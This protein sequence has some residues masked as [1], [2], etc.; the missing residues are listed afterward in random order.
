[1]RQSSIFYWNY[2][3]NKICGKHNRNN[4]QHKARAAHAPTAVCNIHNRP[5]SSWCNTT[6]AP[7][8]VV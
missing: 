5:V 8:I 1:M 6:L 2:I 7:P 3:S 4:T